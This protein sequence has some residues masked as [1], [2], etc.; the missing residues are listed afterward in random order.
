V[1]TKR[2]SIA[3]LLIAGVLTISTA[4]SADGQVKPAPSSSTKAG[5]RAGKIE[6][7]NAQRLVEL[8]Q[9][10][11]DLEIKKAQVDRWLVKLLAGDPDL[12]NA[13]AAA[14][15]AYYMYLPSYYED[16]RR[17]A[18]HSDRTSSSLI[19]ANWLLLGLESI[20][21]LSGIVFTWFQLKHLSSYEV[22]QDGKGSNTDISIRG[23]HITTSVVGVAVLAIALGFLYVIGRGIAGPPQQTF[24]EPAPTAPSG[25]PPSD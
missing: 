18:A 10:L 24:Q 11:S 12:G 3:P 8:E 7:S 16:V 19:Y 15:K 2:F 25:R 14:M 9:K 21:V 22:Q 6:G 23:M 1:S 17:A 20:L 13:R 4:I 5:E